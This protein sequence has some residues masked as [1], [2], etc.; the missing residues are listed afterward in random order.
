MGGVDNKIVQAIFPIAS[1][2]FVQRFHPLKKPELP[3]LVALET[4]ALTNLEQF[5]TWGGVVK[6]AL[7]AKDSCAEI[8][9]DQFL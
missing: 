8:V 7:F 1:E 6:P 3:F 9:N 2:K 4:T 5:I